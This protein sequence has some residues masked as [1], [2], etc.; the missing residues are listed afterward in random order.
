MKRTLLAT[1][2][3]LVTVPAFATAATITVR[4][5]GTGDYM[6]LQQALDVAASGDTVLV[7]PGEYTES[8]MVR[9]NGHGFDSEIFGHVRANNVTLIGA[10]M[11][12]T[13]IGPETY[14]GSPSHDTPKCIAKDA[15]GGWTCISDLTLR[16]CYLGMYVDGVLHVDRC[17]ILDNYIGVGWFNVGS[18][19]WIK[20][21]TIIASAPPGVGGAL[22]FGGLPQ[23]SDITIENC[24]LGWPSTV[25][26]VQN[27][28]IRDCTF[29]GL[30]LY[31]GAEVY[32]ERCVGMLPYGGVNI[33]LGG[34]AYCEIRDCELRSA[35]SASPIAIDSDAPG[36]RVVAENCL[37]EGG[38]SATVY[39]GSGAGPC[40][41][42]N[43]DLVKG[44]GPM[45]ECAFS[46]TQVTHDLSNNW[47]GTTS[48]AEIQA[49]IYDRA[50]NP[51]RGGLVNYRPFAGQSV[52]TEATSWGELKASFR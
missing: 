6:V 2:L 18:G 35:V 49:W 1:L 7:G 27:C 48:E 16:N 4:K 38:A 46:T 25:R 10:G 8:S 50:D 20:D 24:H 42:R 52:P 36:N 13:I 39:L 44:S 5:D 33:V 47:W 12:V 45:V 9:L 29:N 11:G 37:I 28:V 43:C 19:G 17:E 51:G 26:G 21:T 3:V 41:I 30:S 32:M 23:G 15:E 34:G 40:Q 22:S 31:G 14:Y